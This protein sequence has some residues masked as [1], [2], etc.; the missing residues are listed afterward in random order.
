MLAMVSTLGGVG[1]PFS[2]LEMLCFMLAIQ[3]LRLSF[4]GD[5]PIPKRTVCREI[6][7][8]NEREINVSMVKFL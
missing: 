3:W 1:V 7:V 5:V 8:R 6:E 4:W 2:F